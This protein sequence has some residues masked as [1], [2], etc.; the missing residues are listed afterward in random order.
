[1]AV[2]ASVHLAEQIDSM[3]HLQLMGLMSNGSFDTK[4]SKDTT[5]ASPGHARSLKKMK[6]HKIGGANMKHLSM[7]MSQ[8]ILRRPSPKLNHWVRIG[9]ALFGG[10]CRMA[11]RT[12]GNTGRKPVPRRMP[13]HRFFNFFRWVLSII[14]TILRIDHYR[15]VPV[16]LVMSGWRGRNKYIGMLRR[17]LVVH[18]L[19][20]A[21][22]DLLGDVIICVLLC[23]VFLMLWHAHHLIRD[24]LRWRFK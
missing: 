15:P 2:G 24:G 1:V 14:A 21:G 6:W 4:M 17:Y 3:P 7:G 16:R 9:T 11:M 13:E 22:Q 19:R 8:A 20:I 5:I 18:G 10:R 23:V 12:R